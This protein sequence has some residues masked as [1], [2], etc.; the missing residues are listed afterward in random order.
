MR[1]DQETGTER[2]RLG[3]ETRAERGRGRE[4]RPEQGFAMKARRPGFT[5]VEL[6][7]VLGIV[8][9]LMALLLP[10]V[11][12]VRES[13][14]RTRCENNLRQLGLALHSYHD[15]HGWLPAG[16]MSSGANVCDAEA[17]GFTLILPH[18]E[19]DNTYKLYHFDAPW[20]DPSNYTA[21]GTSVKLFFCPSNR[22]AG[23][24]D[25][26]P[27]G[28][29]W[30]FTLPPQAACCD[31]VLCKGASGSLPNDWSRTPESVRGVF[32]IQPSWKDGG[33]RLTDVRDGTAHTFALGEGAGGTPAYLVRSLT[34][35]DQPAL[36]LSGNPVPVEQAWCAAGAGDPS[37][38]WYGS[39]FGVTAQYGLD[40]DPRDEPM[41]R[42]LT[43]PTVYGGDP[44]GDNKQ[45]KNTVSGFRSLH[46]GGCNFLFCDC[47][48]A[49]IRQ[50]IDAATYRALSTYAGAE[51]IAAPSF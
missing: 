45:G 41:N 25:L 15:A 21:V 40:P 36:D 8:G 1:R 5:L 7:V 9:V 16:M 30:G 23:E 10:A 24:L 51:V 13:S 43:A 29:Q 27:I 48:V 32:G 17:T 42:P 31:Y 11:Q 47:H 46:S 22:D 2:V 35:P 44:S 18:L 12:K 26:G 49:F 4:T 3:H 6:L 33:I 50:D 39:V 34:D 19:Q 28:L 37:H 20:W 38:P 14:N